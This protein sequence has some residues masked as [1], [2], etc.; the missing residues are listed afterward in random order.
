MFPDLEEIIIYKT[1]KNFTAINKECFKQGSSK[2]QEY[3]E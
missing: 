2:T 1:I 3:H